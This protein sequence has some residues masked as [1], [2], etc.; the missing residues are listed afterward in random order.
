MTL[1][2][3]QIPLSKNIPVTVITRP[4][5]PYREQER[6]RKCIET[7][8]EKVIVRTEPDVYQKYIIIDDQ[9]VWYGSIGL[10]D[11]INSEDT[12]MRLETKELV[13]ELTILIQPDRTDL[14]P[15]LQP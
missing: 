4:V 5:D 10:L 13:R 7:L 1:D 12:I 15:K 6:Q 14:T 3:L 8:Q 2:L 9:L 11:Y